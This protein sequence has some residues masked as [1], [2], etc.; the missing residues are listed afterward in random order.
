MYIGITNDLI[1]RLYEHKNKFVKGFT[2][3]YN[4][5]KLMYSETV[6][7]IKEAIMREKRLKKWNREWKIKLIE[8]VNKEWRDLSRDII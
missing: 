8:E 3:K 6:D 1:R 4:I 2:N 5:D 7:N